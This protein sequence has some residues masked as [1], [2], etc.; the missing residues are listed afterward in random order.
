MRGMTLDDL[1]PRICIMGPSNSG[2][3]SLAAAISRACGLPPI[4]LDQL[5]YQPHTD[6]QPRPNEEFIALH[7]AAI[8]GERWVIDGN[9]SR[10]LPQRL[11]RA[12]GIPARYLYRDQL[13]TLFSPHM[14]RARSSWRPARRHEQRQLGDAPPHHGHHARKPSALQGNVRRPPPAEAQSRNRRRDCPVLSF[15]RTQK[16]ARSHGCRSRPS[17]SRA[18]TPRCSQDQLGGGSL[19]EPT[20]AGTGA[21]VLATA[22]ARWV[23]TRLY[24]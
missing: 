15:G 10:C 5:Q 16:V 17:R 24:T 2:K 18:A 13:V 20:S 11:G 23:C 3:S 21:T 7:D 4:H 19:P 8:L 22:A 14:V 12:T 1:G 9:Y 6:W